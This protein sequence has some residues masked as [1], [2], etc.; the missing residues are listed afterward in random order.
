[1]AN[2]SMLG[3]RKNLRTHRT[4]SRIRNNHFMDYSLDSGRRGRGQASS[5]TEQKPARISKTIN[6]LLPIDITK[7][8][9]FHDSTA[10][11]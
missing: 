4:W 3:G 9:V 6:L 7:K 10:T 11:N 1:M 2:N 5:F 8:T